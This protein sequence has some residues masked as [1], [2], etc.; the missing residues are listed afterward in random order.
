M[1]RIDLISVL[2]QHVSTV[3]S[4]LH[5]SHCLI[6]TYLEDFKYHLQTGEMVLWVEVLARKPDNLSL[7][8]G[9]MWWKRR[10][11]LLTCPLA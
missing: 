9:T 7:T 4:F 11:T 10:L 5:D 1:V 3:T 8:S 2:I 6:H